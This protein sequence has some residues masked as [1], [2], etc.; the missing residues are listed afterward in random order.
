MKGS[1]LN[2][3]AGIWL[4]IAPVILKYGIPAADIDHITGP[5]IITFAITSFWG[6]TRAVNHW[7]IVAGFWLFISPVILSYTEA[8]AA[9]NSF[10][11]GILILIFSSF[12]SK[13]KQSFGGGWR[14]LWKD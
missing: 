6:V 9:I 14:G 1:I 3:L 7:N 12:K 11:S 8:S 2:L 13:P 4:M 10:I 5:I